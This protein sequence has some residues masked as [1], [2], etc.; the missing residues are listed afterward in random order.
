[1]LEYKPADRTNESNKLGKNEG[2]E[3]R[4][5]ESCVGYTHKATIRSR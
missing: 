5:K 4:Q 1:M 2:V 3:E